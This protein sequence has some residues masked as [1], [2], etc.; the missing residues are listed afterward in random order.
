MLTVW[1]LLY[2][3]V[4]LAFRVSNRNKWWWWWWWWW[5]YFWFKKDM[6]TDRQPAHRISGSSVLE[7]VLIHAHWRMLFYCWWCSLL[8]RQHLFMVFYWLAMSYAMVNPLIYFW[9]NKRWDFLPHLPPPVP[10][11]IPEAGATYQA[12]SPAVNVYIVLL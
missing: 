10:I 2:L 6:G 4:A 3:A 9:M 11:L 7:G 5:W 8:C 12:S 1:S